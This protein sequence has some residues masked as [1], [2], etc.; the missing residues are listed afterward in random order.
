MYLVV[1]LSPIE[2]MLAFIVM[3]CPKAVPLQIKMLCFMD[4]AG[5]LVCSPLLFFNPYMTVLTN[6]SYYKV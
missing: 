3:P 4:S 5:I 6:C 1:F 2:A